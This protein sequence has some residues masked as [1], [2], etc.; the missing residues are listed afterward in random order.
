MV[1]DDFSKRRRLNIQR[2]ISIAAPGVS[3]KKKGNARA[4]EAL[5]R[6][7]NR[8]WKYERHVVKILHRKIFDLSMYPGDIDA[9]A[10]RSQ[11]CVDLIKA[12][13]EPRPA[14]G[15]LRCAIAFEN[16][17]PISRST[18]SSC[19][20]S[21]ST[22]LSRPRTELEKLS[23]FFLLQKKAIFDCHTKTATNP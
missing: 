8:H 5:D 1:R 15:Q 18:A 14:Y 3:I 23:S 13:A 17:T 11:W 4:S 21:S 10:A 20:L 7:I 22:D 9:R 6:A 16:R 2:S 12:I 19:A